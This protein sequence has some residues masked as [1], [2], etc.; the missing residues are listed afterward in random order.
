MVGRCMALVM[1]LGGFV[2]E[3]LFKL[4]AFEDELVKDVLSIDFLRN[5]EVSMILS[6]LMRL[7]SL[8]SYWMKTWGR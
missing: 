7:L 3:D 1:G 6:L 5:C 8:S 2:I 4:F